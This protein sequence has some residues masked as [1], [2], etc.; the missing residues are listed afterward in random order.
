MTTVFKS[1][2]DHKVEE[3][4]ARTMIYKLIPD[5]INQIVEREH[6]TTIYSTVP[7]PPPPPPPPPPPT[8]TPRSPLLGGL[9]YIEKNDPRHPLNGTLIYNYNT[10]D[11]DEYTSSSSYD[12][13]L[14]SSRRPPPVLTENC[15]TQTEMTTIYFI[16]RYYD[17]IAMFISDFFECLFGH[18]F[19]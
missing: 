9:V 3:M 2:S 17:K 19:H 5:I 1:Q 12:S 11:E 13:S 15:G 6:S 18:L 16:V 14:S 4:E 10:C 8:P 7:Q